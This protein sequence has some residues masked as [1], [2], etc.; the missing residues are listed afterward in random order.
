MAAPL[1]VLWPI[2]AEALAFILRKVVVSFV[3]FAAL[4]TLLLY[5]MPK[6]LEM[7][8]GYTGTSE[9]TSMWSYLP[10]AAFW[11]LRVGGLDTGLPTVISAVVTRF[12]IRR[13]PVIG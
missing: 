5:L 9:L 11:W 4:E 1:L 13:L 3:I 7:V 10:D 6:L 2:V 12:L 8:A